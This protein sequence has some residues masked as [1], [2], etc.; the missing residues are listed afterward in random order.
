MMTTKAL[1][2]SGRARSA[3]AAKPRPNHAATPTATARKATPSQ[4]PEKF[5]YAL[6]PYKLELRDKGWYVA[7]T[8][9]VF[10]EERDQWIG[11]FELLEN[12]A[13]CAARRWM[14]EAA[15]RHTK[16]IEWFALDAR[17]P[18]YGLKK[19]TKPKC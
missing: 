18:L 5:S 12:A 4:V 19:T 13:L 2:N 11:P 6:S 16:A 1:S 7:R 15:D 17:H 10:P 3:T 8:T 14:V 9:P